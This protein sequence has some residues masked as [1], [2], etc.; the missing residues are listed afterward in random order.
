VI[1]Q[2]IDAIEFIFV[3]R[4][5]RAGG[6]SVGG[7]ENLPLLWAH[8]K[9][10][11]A[12][13]A[14]GLALALPIGLVLGHLGRGSFVA[15]TTS[16]VGRAVPS[17]AL[18][19]LFVS[20]FPRSSEFLNVVLALG[21][22]AVPPILTNTY[23]GIRQVSDDAIDA[24]RG[25]GMT[26]REIVRKV[27]LPLALPLIFGGIK[28]STV[29]VVATATIAPLVGVLTLGDPIT[30]QSVYGRE[31]LIGAAIIVALLAVA[32]EVGLSAVQRAVTP[33]GVKL[34]TPIEGKVLP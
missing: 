14:V 33:G 1:E 30:A 34:E 4:E 6:A 26:G 5:S 8:L 25:M 12:A 23:V 10:T 28:T 7:A 2:F 31:G 22:L 27:E 29:N 15:I 9:L 21:V 11:L 3:S 16:N 17:V 13:M 24:A 32:A 19:A 18:I 20:F